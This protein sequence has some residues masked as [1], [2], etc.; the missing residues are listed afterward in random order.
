M[1]YS[2]D[3]FGSARDF[4]WNLLH[5]FVVLAEAGSVTAAAERLGRKQPTVSNAL[6][7]LEEQIGK[8]LIDRSPGKFVLTDAGR[9]LHR[10]AIDIYGSVVRLN[11]LLRDVTDEVRGHVKIA[12]ASHVVCPLFD[13][14]L[15]A[16]HVAH[17]RATLTL[18]VMASVTTLTEVTARRASLAIC[19]VHERSPKL[20]Y[21][22]LYREYFGLFC[23]PG[24]PL[25]GRRGLKSSN[26]KGHSSVGFMTDRLDDALRPVAL[27]RAEAGLDQHVVGTS[28]HL[29]E[30]RR[31]TIAGLGIGALPMHVVAR[32]VA[33]G[34]LWQLP[35]Y[36][37]PPAIDVHLVW[38]PKARMNR[39]EETFLGMLTER[40]DGTPIKQR[41]YS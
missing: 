20:E 39:A 35:P 37:A 15:R 25:F 19:L 38:N 9:L 21:R 32:D 24:H 41:T 12:M 40:I 29:E 1:T 18:D 23:G 36:D 33:E 17:P 4:D 27:I 22:R 26:L 16:F 31:M 6:R 14:A 2:S 28:S 3:C 11:T 34:L 10:E 5:T 8:Q 13:D 7:R 30:V